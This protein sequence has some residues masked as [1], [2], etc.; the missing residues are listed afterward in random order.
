MKDKY[1]CIRT[2]TPLTNAALNNG[3]VVIKI[4]YVKRGL[5]FGSLLKNNFD[6]RLQHSSSL[7]KEANVIDSGM[8]D[9]GLVN[10]AAADNGKERGSFC[11]RVWLLL[12]TVF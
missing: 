8:F 4:A 7:E 9:D 11:L 12:Y 3:Y 1:K 10:D 5:R 2:K 6:R